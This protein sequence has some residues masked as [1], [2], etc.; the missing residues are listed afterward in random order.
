MA[1]KRTGSA[2]GPATNLGAQI[3]ELIARM[4]NIEQWL[5]DLHPDHCGRVITKM[6]E[7]ET[8]TR[9]LYQGYLQ[10]AQAEAMASES[11]LEQLDRNVQ[12]RL[13]ALSDQLSKD[14]ANHAANAAA[15]RKGMRD[16]EQSVADNIGALISGVDNRFSNERES[17]LNVIRVCADESVDRLHT[18]AAALN[19]ELHD[20]VSS[21]SSLAAE[22]VVGE[23]RGRGLRF[24]TRQGAV[25]RA[26]SRDS[27]RG[28]LTSHISEAQ[29]VASLRSPRISA[30]V[31]SPCD[32]H[33]T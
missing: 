20:V 16:L 22:G 14:A 10:Q 27:S 4:T 8:N 29:V 5:M 28:S 23:T 24:R 30:G 1:P 15:L 9:K 6:L 33:H 17:V 2:S 26:S 3:T 31:V 19:C 18:T 25:I 11:R 12:D 13:L 7:I 21:R 32:A